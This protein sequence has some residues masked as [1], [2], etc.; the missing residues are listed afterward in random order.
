MWFSLAFTPDVCPLA[1]ALCSGLP[2]PRCGLSPWSGRP[3]MSFP[4]LIVSGC[5]ASCRLCPGHRAVQ[6]GAAEGGN[7]KH[8]ATLCWTCLYQEAAWHPG[9]EGFLHRVLYLQTGVRAGFMGCQGTGV[10]HLLST[11]CTPWYPLCRVSAPSP[12]GTQALVQVS[13]PASCSHPASCTSCPH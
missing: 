4:F 12:S 8:N 1:Q 5:C 2:A 13:N 3:K 11:P 9:A 6:Q 7:S 10:L